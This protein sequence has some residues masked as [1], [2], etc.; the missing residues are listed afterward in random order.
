MGGA[1]IC[2]LSE[3]GDARNKERTAVGSHRLGLKCR[4]TYFGPKASNPASRSPWVD[5]VVREQGL[6]GRSFVEVG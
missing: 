1:S 2:D 3:G 6:C 5:W 4:A